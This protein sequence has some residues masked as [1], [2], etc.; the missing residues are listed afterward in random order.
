M[1]WKFEISEPDPAWPVRYAAAVAELRPL[2]PMAIAF[3]HVGSTSIP[4]MPAIATIDILAG[5]RDLASIDATIVGSV[6][7]AGWEHRPDVEAIVPNRRFFNR[8]VGGEFR[9]TRTHQLHIVEMNSAEW[10]DPITFR[11]FLRKDDDAARRYLELKRSLASR[12]YEN[13]SDYSAQKEAFV[14]SILLAAHGRIS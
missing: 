4:R 12:E 10:C 7:A 11:D 8:P 9:T 1:R 3:E 6:V 13:P 2:L 5:V 14:V